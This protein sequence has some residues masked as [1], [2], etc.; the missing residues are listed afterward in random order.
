[1]NRPKQ[2]SQ[3]P[4][5]NL[6]V[7]HVIESLGVAGAEQALVNLLP[8]L[9][10]EGVESE[11]AVLWSP[12]DL[13]QTVRE[14]GIT[15]HELDIRSKWSFARATSQLSHILRKGK[16][17]LAHAHLPGAVF[18]A[19][20][21][22]GRTPAVATF[23]GL[24]FQFYPANTFLRKLRRRAESWW[25]RYRID[26]YIA[27]S[28]AVAEHYH[29]TLGVSLAK[30]RVI[31]N[32]FPTELLRQ[33]A[34]PDAH[35]IRQRFG[36]RPEDFCIVSA[37][38]FVA[39]KGHS[40]LITAVSRLK[41]RGLTPKVLLFGKGGLQPVL[42]AQV[43]DLGLSTQ[44][45]LHP[46]LP[47]QELIS[48]FHA[49]DLFVFPSVSEGFGMAAGEAMCAG[50][51]VV[52]SNIPGIASLIENEISGSLVPP[53][54]PDALAKEVERLILD[55]QLRRKFSLAGRERIVAQFSMGKITA[56]VAAFYREL[57]V[58]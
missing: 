12:Y 18:Y 33:D 47:H 45:S 6:R 17:D 29:Q 21:A 10:R 56:Q 48:L 43:Q 7:L 50:L 55:A 42:E 27:V 44:V 58:A 26:Q 49:A 51:P 35:E 57:V 8:E 25:T 15:V 41:G 11:I 28:S 1:M 3:S 9:R 40:H 31:P 14:Q 19:A 16:F 46:A 38:R 2:A 37:G 52:A 4:I 22:R 24:S 20:V 5:R 36:V 23:H 30:T 32:G 53:G 39:Q 34:A 13:A 54:D